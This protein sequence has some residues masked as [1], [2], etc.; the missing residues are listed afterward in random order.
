MKGDETRII[1]FK[2]GN[3][4]ILVFFCTKKMEV[5]SERINEYWFG[6][7]FRLN[8]QQKWFPTEQVQRET[9]KYILDNFTG[10]LKSAED[11]ELNSWREEP[12]SLVA[13]IVVLDQFSRHIYRNAETRD[14]ITSNDVIALSLAEE[15]LA[16]Q[17]HHKIGTP[18]M[19]FSLMPLRHTPT[20][21]RL[22][23]VL[24][25]ISQRSTELDDSSELLER[26]KKTTDRKLQDL[27][28]EENWKPGKEILEFY[29]FD[30]DE[31]DMNSQ[32]LYQS[33]VRFL[34]SKNYGKYKVFTVSL[35]G[36]VDSMVLLT[37]LKK[38]NEMQ[39]NKFQLYAIHI[40]YGNRP[41]SG[42]EANFVEDWCN[43]KGINFRKTVIE[44][45][46]RRN[47]KRDEYERITRELRFSSYVK[48]L[49]ELQGECPSIMFG[50]HI[51]DV[52]ENIISNMMKGCSLLD[53][54]GMYPESIVNSVTIWRPMLTH[55]KSDIFA[56]AHKYGIPYFLDTTPKWSTRGKMRNQ[57]MP[58]LKDMYGDGFLQH[59]TN[60]AEDSIQ[61]SSIV[62]NQFL[63]PFWDSVVQTR[64]CIYFDFTSYMGQPILFWKEALTHVCHNMLST[65]LIG[66]KSIKEMLQRRFRQ[67][68]YPVKGKKPEDCFIALKK[69]N[70]TFA[71]D[72]ILIIYR[73]EFFPRSNNKSSS[74]GLYY[75]KEQEIEIGKEYQFGPW[76]VTT[77]EVPLEENEDQFYQKLDFYQTLTGDITYFLP[78]TEKYYIKPEDKR[79]PIRGIDAITKSAIPL[80]ACNDGKKKGKTN[81]IDKDSLLKVR[82]IGTM[83]GWRENQT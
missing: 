9:D 66:E 38:F 6:G 78:R 70:R 82:I 53:L 67:T 27:E 33:V 34:E 79:I 58:L 36:G 40:D 76:K 28:V 18:E 50:H 17:W 22:N 75:T 25:V 13:L 30:A 55:P 15:L 71:K 64:V 29:E 3:D 24:E 31:S 19:I 1:K 61:L 45:I 77:E 52:Q 56:F 21:E 12:R 32:K 4:Q 68:L 14:Q 57:L 39:Q 48:L 37:I 35:S 62:T 83:K 51:G 81:I 59:L 20:V 72:N 54:S 42:D 46:T 73:E 43:R 5:T 16:K 11:G 63:Q 65:G 8:F 26:F 49:N 7:D 69:N 2:I 60:L 47:T 23:R 74:F 44:G 80:V 41:E 10:I